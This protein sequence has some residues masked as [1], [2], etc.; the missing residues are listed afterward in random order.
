MRNYFIE[1]TN[2]IL[3]LHR[4]SKR[5]IAIISDATLCVLCTLLAF[6][7]RS[8]YWLALK[9]RLDVSILFSDFNVVSAL[10]SAMIAIPIFWLFGL[11]RTIFRYTSFSIFFTILMSSCVY[12]I[13]YYSIAVYGTNLIP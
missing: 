7:V 13:L 1:F 6:T 11:Y 2:N 12:G 8:E 3:S 10:I 4:Y 9:P 5:T